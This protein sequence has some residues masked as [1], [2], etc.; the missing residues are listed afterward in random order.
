MSSGYNQI[1]QFEVTDLDSTI[2]R[3]AQLGAHL[4]GPI[5]YPA[6]GKVST[7]RTDQGFMIGLY[8]PNV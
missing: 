6:H 2:A 8:E 1:L 3:C 5:V 4:D 7:M